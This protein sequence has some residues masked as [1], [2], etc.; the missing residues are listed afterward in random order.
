MA[1]E[2]GT[3]VRAESPRRTGSS[4]GCVDPAA[5]DTDTPSRQ[6]EVVHRGGFRRVVAAR[7]ADPAVLMR[8]TTEG[9]LV[10]RVAVARPPRPNHA[11][12]KK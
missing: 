7:R 3:G 8:A 10:A 9:E 12:L 2:S 4:A 11:G 5:V 1:P 6:H